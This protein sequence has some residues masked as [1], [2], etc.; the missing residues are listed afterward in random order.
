MISGINKTLFEWVKELEGDS[1]YIKSLEYFLSL[2]PS[3]WKER[4]ET[5]LKITRKILAIHQKQ[6]LPDL[7]ERLS[8]MERNLG[9]IT[10]YQRDHVCH[11]VLTFIV[12]NWVMTKLDLH[13]CRNM[14]FQWKLASLLHDV[15]YSIEIGNNIANKIYED[16]ERNLL[17]KQTYQYS[18]HPCGKLRE[19][20]KMYSGNHSYNTEMLDLF[21]ERF[22]KWG[23]KLDANLIFNNMCEGIAIDDSRLRADH[24]IVSSIFVVKSIDSK[25]EEN[26]WKQII[27][28]Y[29]PWN[30]ENITNHIVN[31]GASIFLHN[32]EREDLY[33][34]FNKMPLATLL[35]VCDELQDWGRPLE[36][37]PSGNS[38]NDYNI[39][40]QNN[41]I[42]F[43]VI[44]NKYESYKEKFKKI[45]NFPIEIQ[46]LT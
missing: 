19:Y 2:R 40:F 30:Y 18:P 29:D 13:K 31:V 44:E 11:A 26:N 16:F 36:C 33:W 25:Y 37:N 35:K 5:A 39:T 17:K 27:D 20:S 42:I 46:E 38:P 41:K 34:D 12:G 22:E 10:P 21:T 15:G 23:L 24:G 6:D 7:A 28:Q 32:L 45:L 43:T 8:Q 14:F 4:Q 9:E 3:S 1:D